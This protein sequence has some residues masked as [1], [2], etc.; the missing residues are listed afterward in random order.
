MATRNHPE[1]YTSIRYFPVRYKSY[2]GKSSLYQRALNQKLTTR[3]TQAHKRQAHNDPRRKSVSL[4]S[5]EIYRSTGRFQAGRER[6]A[7]DSISREQRWFMIC[8]TY[9]R[10]IVRTASRG[11]VATMELTEQRVP[12]H[13]Y[14]TA[15]GVQRRK[16]RPPCSEIKIL[17]ARAVLSPRSSQPPERR[18]LGLIFQLSNQ[19]GSTGA[20]LPRAFPLAS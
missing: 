13:E 12:R 3:L 6:Y 14:E 11:I 20:L 2:E 7:F 17:L 19:D 9:F 5:V 15:R 16:K 18:R 1:I 4:S 10:G 8:G